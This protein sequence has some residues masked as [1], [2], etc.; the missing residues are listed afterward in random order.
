MS[1]GTPLGDSRRI[2][3]FFLVILMVAVCPDRPPNL[4]R[5]PQKFEVH[6]ILQLVISQPVK[7]ELLKFF[8]PAHGHDHALM[9]RKSLSTFWMSFPFAYAAAARVV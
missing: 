4:L 8:D 1:A 7:S 6:R 9:F 3:H 2:G 5:I